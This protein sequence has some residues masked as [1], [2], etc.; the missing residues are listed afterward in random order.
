MQWLGL[1]V[2]WNE[3]LVAAKNWYSAVRAANDSFA[4]KGTANDHTQGD[5]AG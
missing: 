4:S 3:A 5:R 1:D 2:D